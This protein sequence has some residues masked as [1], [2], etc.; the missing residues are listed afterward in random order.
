MEETWRMPFLQELMS[1]AETKERNSP[2]SI[3]AYAMKGFI[4]NNQHF[5]LYSEA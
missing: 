4:N 1:L 5:E 2:V 3:L